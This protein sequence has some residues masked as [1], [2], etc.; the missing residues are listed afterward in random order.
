MDVFYYWKDYKQ[1]QQA[2]RIGYF[3][4]SRD[5]LD[6]LSAGAPD[7]IWVFKT[8]PGH[9]GQV[10]LLARLR[11]ADHAVR[12]VPK[13]PGVVFIHYDPAAPMS[14]RYLNSDTPEAI[15]AATTWVRRHFPS[16]IR[17]NFQGQSG[18]ECLRGPLLHELEKLAAT[19]DAEPFLVPVAAPAAAPA[20]VP[21]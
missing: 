3:K 17:G 6:V 2:G 19:F 21:S 11:W 16:M 12:P 10:Q 7:N 15:A 13:E 18:Q 5:K 8:P 14:V 1:D 4:S 20:T 9:K